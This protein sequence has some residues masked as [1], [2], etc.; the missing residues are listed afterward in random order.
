VLGLRNENIRLRGVDHIAAKLGRFAM[1]ES[2][3]LGIGIIFVGISS[4]RW[5]Q[6]VRPGAALVQTGGTER[7]GLRGVLFGLWI[8][9]LPLWFLI[10]WYWYPTSENIAV[11]QYGHKVWSDLWAA[12]AVV[13]GVLFG[14]KKF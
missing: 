7:D 8:V 3:I 6:E 1:I 12:L 9:G 14:L 5:S 10:Q 13:L 4:Y 2:I 11:Y